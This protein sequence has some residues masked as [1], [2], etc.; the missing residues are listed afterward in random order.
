MT[1]LL[2]LFP[3]EIQEIIAEWLIKTSRTTIEKSNKETKYKIF[4]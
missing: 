2:T 3:K 4:K 1:K